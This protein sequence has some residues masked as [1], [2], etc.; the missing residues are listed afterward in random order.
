MI[1]GK[2]LIGYTLSGNSDKTF[3]GQGGG[4]KEISGIVFHEADPN[5][6][7][8]AATKANTAFNTY[9]H[10]STEKKITFL[11]SVTSKLAA[12]KDAIIKV[13]VQESKLSINRLEG[14]MQ[15]TINQIKL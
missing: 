6:I 3:K 10:F 11:E 2:N 9:R 4:V 7:G 1:T 14:E 8:E 15:R 5:E 13:T 12:S